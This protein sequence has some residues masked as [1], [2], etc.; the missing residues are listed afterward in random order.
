MSEYKIQCLKIMER[1]SFAVTHAT[2][3]SSSSYS[4][5]KPNGR[6]GK[7]MARDQFFSSSY[8][9]EEERIFE[10]VASPCALVV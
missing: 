6:G 1:E 4:L 9:G 10:A 2:F 3:I 7:D 8:Q 5:N